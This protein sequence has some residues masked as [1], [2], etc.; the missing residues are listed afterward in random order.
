[1][2]NLRI[3]GC[4]NWTLGVLGRNCNL[5]KTCCKAKWR[6][7]CENHISHESRMEAVIVYRMVLHCDFDTLP[8]YDRKILWAL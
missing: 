8:L 1:M 2:Y 3:D 6:G 7:W 4:L 5:F